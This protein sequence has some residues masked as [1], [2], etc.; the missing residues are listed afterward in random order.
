MPSGRLVQV[1]K[2]PVPLLIQVPADTPPENNKIQSKYLD[3]ATHTG[4]LS[5]EQGSRI[6][7]NYLGRI[8]PLCICISLFHSALQQIFYKEEGGGNA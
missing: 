3:P 6:H 7:C 8:L 2:P 5:G 1:L 4:D